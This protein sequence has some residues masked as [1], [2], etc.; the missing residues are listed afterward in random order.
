MQGSISFLYTDTLNE[1]KILNN[2]TFIVATKQYLVIWQFSCD[3]EL[4]Y[5]SW[6]K[7]VPLTGQPHFCRPP[8]AQ[9]FPGHL[10]VWPPG[11]QSGDSHTPSL[12]QF[13]EL[14]KALYSGRQCCYK[15]C[16]SWSAKRKDPYGKVLEG[17]KCEV[18][19][20]FSKHVDVC[21]PPGT[22]TQTPVFR[23]FT[24]VSFCRCH[25]LNNWPL[26]WT[27]FPAPQRSNR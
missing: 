17:P 5:T 15:G 18:S 20:S 27:Q 4:G 21:H 10:C 7:N 9:E 12:E 19:L 16:K 11:Y 25:W 14:R 3:P 2:T 24:G 6:V 1:N 26:G 23:A 13:I 22:L 8:Q